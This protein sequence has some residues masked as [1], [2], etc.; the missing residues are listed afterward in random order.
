MN[1]YSRIIIVTFCEKYKLS[2]IKKL[3]FYKHE[4]NN[5]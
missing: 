3:H 5:L 2:D 1:E 4:V